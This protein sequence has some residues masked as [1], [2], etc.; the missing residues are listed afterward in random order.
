MLHIALDARL[1]EP[2]L[3]GGSA[4]FVKQLSRYLVEE[5]EFR[6]SLLVKGQI[7]EPV[8]TV[9]DRASLIR[10]RSPFLSLAEQIELPHLLRRIQPDLFHSPTFMALRWSPCP[11]VQTIYD[12][13]HL[14]FPHYYPRR[15]I[16]FYRR[17]LL[18]AAR[19][20]KRIMTTSNFSASEIVTHLGI[21]R[22]RITVIPL[23]V[24]EIFQAHVEVPPDFRSRYGLPESFFLYLGNRKPHKNLR[25]LMD[26]YERAR[27]GWS[28]VIAGESDGGRFRVFEEEARKRGVM[29]LDDVP[30]DDLPDLYRSASAFVFP[31]RYEGFGLPPLEAMACGVPV[32]CSDAASL[33]EAV[34][35]AAIQVGPDDVVGWSDAM[36]L[37][38]NDGEL[39]KALR[40]RGLQQAAAFPW[41]RCLERTAAWYRGSSGTSPGGVGPFGAI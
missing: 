2:S 18:P 37:I 7:R 3:Q 21:A 39:R 36:R 12:V 1:T 11:V 30:E 17:V 29:M 16:F 34:G 10:V 14:A 8:H 28:L 25:L 40:R 19:R 24:D 38:S 26:A 33:P 35:K 15:H 22:E 27:I 6:V 23:G 13:N 32:I 20:T 5:T 31:S 41:R 4:R 9:S